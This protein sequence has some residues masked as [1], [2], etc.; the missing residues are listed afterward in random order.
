MTSAFIKRVTRSEGFRRLAC[1]LV[2]AY[3]RLVHRTTRW[4]IEGLERAERCWGQNQP[5]IGAFWHG[6]ML[7]IPCF[8]PSPRPI[9][10]LISRHSD[11]E[12][13]RRTIGHFGIDAI[14]GSTGKGGGEALRQIVRAL[15]SGVSVG[16]TPDGP[17]GP[18][19]RASLG[20]VQTARLAQVPILP[21]SVATSRRRVLASWDRFQIALPFSRGAFVW[22]EPIEV[23]ADADAAALERLRQVLESRLNEAGRE[24]DRLVGQQPIEPAALVGNHAE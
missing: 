11:G 22:G 14:A 8:W 17:R 4:R 20:A 12:L 24:A 7:M 13:I 10:M 23:P 18:G 3:I 16:M 6:R 5:F 15:R 21:V 2:A 19:M 1:P 9:S